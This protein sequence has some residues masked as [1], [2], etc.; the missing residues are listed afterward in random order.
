MSNPIDNYF[1]AQPKI[2]G[3]VRAAI[4]KA[5][6]EAEE[7]ISYNIPTYKIGGRAV[8]YLAG[9]KEHFSIYPIGAAFGDEIKPYI[10]GKGTLKFPFARK[11]PI[12]LIARIAK[13]RA[14]EAR[15]KGKM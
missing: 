11:A 10:A 1:A 12:T 4:R 15:A 3:R 2:L 7:T 5:M 13:F 8:L 9:W 6:P 14:A